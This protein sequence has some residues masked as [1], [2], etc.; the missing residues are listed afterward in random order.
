MTSLGAVGLGALKDACTSTRNRT[1][2][3]HKSH[4]IVRVIGHEQF[5]L[6]HLYKIQLRRAHLKLLKFLLRIS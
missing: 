3:H 2:I 1:V 6:L 4:S 5:V